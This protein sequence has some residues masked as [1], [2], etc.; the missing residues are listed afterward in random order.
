MKVHEVVF[1]CV[2]LPFVV[3]LAACGYSA[4]PTKPVVA[5]NALAIDSGRIPVVKVREFKLPGKE[6]GTVSIIV[7]PDRNLWFST[8]RSIVRMTTSGKMSQSFL[9]KWES[10]PGNLTVGSDQNIW[11]NAAEFSPSSGTGGLSASHSYYEIYKVTPGLRRTAYALPPNTNLFATDLVR[12]GTYL[13]FGFPTIGSYH[14]ST[15]FNNWVAS[16]SPTGAIKRLFKVHGKENIGGD[17]WINVIETPGPKLW[18]YDYLGYIEVCTLQRKCTIRTTAYPSLY[19]GGLHTM[20]MA[21]S[22]VAKAVY[23]VNLNNYTV[24]KLLLQGGRKRFIN[25]DIYAGGGAIAYYHSNVWVALGPDS[26]GRP[27]LGRLTPSDEFSEIALPIPHARQGV[28]A[29]APG[30]DGHLWYVRGYHV[31]EILSR[32]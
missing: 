20:M 6:L 13:Y 17:G 25:R 7:G 27:K 5:P 12:I 29:F 3:A 18:L 23:V 9:K 30:P 1:R 28:T 4:I 11:A 21:Y 15:T 26:Q 19:L 24:F 2:I 31:G 22:P 32:L 14:G 8:L 16:V 10:D